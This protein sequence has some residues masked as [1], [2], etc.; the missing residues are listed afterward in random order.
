MKDSEGNIIG[1]S[2]LVHENSGAEV[3]IGGYY[4]YNLVLNA[5]YYGEDE[6]FFIDWEDVTYSLRTTSDAVVETATDDLMIAKTTGL[7]EGKTYFFTSSSDLDYF[8]GDSLKKKIDSI[9]VR[10]IGKS[11]DGTYLYSF[12]FTFSEDQNFA[13]NSKFILMSSN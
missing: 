1:K 6:E 11:Q 5:N 2:I 13:P 3:Q 12:T 10:K 9:V 7:V 8:I 4:V